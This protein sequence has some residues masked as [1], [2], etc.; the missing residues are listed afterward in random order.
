VLQ[1]S[2]TISEWLYNGLDNY[3][4]LT[5]DRGYFQLSR[6]IDRRLYEVARKHCGDQPLWKIG[7]DLLAGKL[8]TR[9]SR[10]KFRDELRQAIKADALPEYRIALDTNTKPDDVVFYTR[11]RAKLA[12][13]L[14]RT[15]RA[16]WFSTLARV[17]TAPVN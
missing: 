12:K 14:L 7:I 10:A 1:F 4:V 9:V 15:E 11:N 8:G 2:V 13:E 6:S 3:E 5:M 16:N 17:E